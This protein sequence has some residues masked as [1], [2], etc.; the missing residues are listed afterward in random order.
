MVR[1]CLAM[2][3]SGERVERLAGGVVGGEGEGKSGAKEC[4]LVGERKGRP[5]VD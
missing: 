2:L 4:S 3:N 5:G 1:E